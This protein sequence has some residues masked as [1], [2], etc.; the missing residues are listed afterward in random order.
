MTSGQNE[1]QTDKQTVK[2]MKHA[3]WPKEIETQNMIKKK[4]KKKEYA[5]RSKLVLSFS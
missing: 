5:E 2:F 1:T 4:K 3:A